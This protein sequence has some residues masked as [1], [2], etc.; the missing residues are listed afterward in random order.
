MRLVRGTEQRA[1]SPYSTFP[2]DLKTNGSRDGVSILYSTV[3]FG[4]PPFDLGMT[5]VHEV[6]HWLGLLHPF[7]GGCSEDGDF[8]ADTPPEQGPDFQCTI[9][10]DTCDGDGLDDVTNIM[11]YNQDACMDHL[12]EGQIA[13]VIAMCS[14]Y[15]PLAF[16]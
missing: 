6:G 7:Q 10:R 12:T 3:P 15:R 5:T 13:R 2:W 4:Q 14:R 8:V 9:G 1:A 16:R 11:G